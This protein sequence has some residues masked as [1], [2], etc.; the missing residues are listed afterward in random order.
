MKYEF[1]TS[2]YGLLLHFFYWCIM[3]HYPFNA[4]KYNTAASLCMCICS[5][6]PPDETRR[7]NNN[8]HHNWSTV[9]LVDKVYMV[10]AKQLLS[11]YFHSKLSARRI[12]WQWENNV[13]AK[14]QKITTTWTGS[15]SALNSFFVDFIT[16]CSCPPATSVFWF[17][18]AGPKVLFSATAGSC[19]YRKCKIFSL[20]L[21]PK[22]PVCQFWLLLLRDCIALFKNL[23]VL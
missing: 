4:V 12:T 11:P 16:L 5:N 18:L 15:C 6:A 3:V 9:S 7:A 2:V 19:Y 17:S 8:A 22:L 1:F 21:S 14:Q 13:T 10:T 23:G 20:F